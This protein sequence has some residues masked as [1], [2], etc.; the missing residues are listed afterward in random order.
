VKEIPIETP[1]ALQAN[2]VRKKAKQE[3][4][5]YNASTLDQVEKDYLKTISS[6]EKKAKK[7]SRKKEGKA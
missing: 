7:E 5:R 2:S 4:Q 3:L 1:A 6:L